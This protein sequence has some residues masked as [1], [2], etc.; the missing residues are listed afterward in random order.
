MIIV[1]I[2]DEALSMLKV[3]L[4]LKYWG[5]RLVWNDNRDSIPR[6]AD[7]RDGLI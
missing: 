6:V 1:G 7:E 5:I 4:Q 2:G 3:T